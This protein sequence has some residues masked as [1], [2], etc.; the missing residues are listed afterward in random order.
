MS[1]KFFGF[2]DLAEAAIE[3]QDG[4][5]PLNPDDGM[6]LEEVCEIYELST[7]EI[8]KVTTLSVGEA[9]EV[10]GQKPF[11]FGHSDVLKRIR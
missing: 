10:F 7:D 4:D 1:K 6:S 2:H 9:L 11:G 3:D 5:E 8:E